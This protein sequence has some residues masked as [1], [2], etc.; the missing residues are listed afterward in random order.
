[1]F[2]RLLSLWN[3]LLSG[4]VQFQERYVLIF[5]SS[6]G[7]IFS[8]ITSSAEWE[9]IDTKCIVCSFMG[10]VSPSS[11]YCVL[12]DIYIEDGIIL[13]MEE[14]RITTWHVWS[15]V[16]TRIWYVWIFT[17]STVSSSQILPEPSKGTIQSSNHRVPSNLLRRIL[18]SDRGTVWITLP[19]FSTSLGVWCICRGISL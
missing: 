3:G 16:N 4:V 18:G 1:M 2:G 11:T 10:Y 12:P 15:P 8:V 17:I 6:L 9:P 5:C 13:F 19:S 7:P 14:I